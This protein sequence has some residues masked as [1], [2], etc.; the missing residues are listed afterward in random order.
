M[1]GLDDPTDLVMRFGLPPP[2]SCEFF[3]LPPMLTFRFFANKECLFS[4]LALTFLFRVSEG[5]RP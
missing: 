5:L 2:G 1:V 3:F 4:K